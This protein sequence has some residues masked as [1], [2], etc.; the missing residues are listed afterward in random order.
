MV[1]ITYLYSDDLKIMYQVK[2]KNF[3]QIFRFNDFIVSISVIFF[4]QII[5]YTDSH[6]ILFT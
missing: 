5:L 2:I 6:K 4:G 1:V 3:F